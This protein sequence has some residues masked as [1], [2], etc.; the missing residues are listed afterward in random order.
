VGEGADAGCEDGCERS[1]GWGEVVED[2]LRGVCSSGSVGSTVSLTYGSG[3]LF[4]RL[5]NLNGWM[6][7]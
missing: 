6:D 4:G 2:Y 7:G 3:D 1:A 5:M